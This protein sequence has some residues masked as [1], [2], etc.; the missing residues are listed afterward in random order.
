LKI[1]VPEYTGG[2]DDT[3]FISII[4]LCGGGIALLLRTVIPLVYAG[5]VPTTGTP[6]TI[7]FAEPEIVK[8]PTRFTGQPDTVNDWPNATPEP[9]EDVT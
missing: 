3:K 4:E 2:A 9:V 8:E 5:S 1:A 6:V 7:Q